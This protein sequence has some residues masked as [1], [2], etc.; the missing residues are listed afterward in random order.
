MSTSPNVLAVKDKVQRWLNDAVGTITIDPDGDFTFRFGSTQI[1]I[2]VIDQ[3][4]RVLVFLQMPLLF[5]VPLTPELYKY[6]ATENTYFFGKLAVSE[7]DGVGSLL[8]LH[9][10][11][12][13]YLD[14]EE[15]HAAIRGM[16]NTGDE[17]DNELQARFGGTVFHDD[18]E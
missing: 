13:D 9:T 16:V 8:F 4:D 7:R 6:V 5:E 14:A 10:L 3:E 18:D 2:R 15:L 11:L 17:L 12:G 1:F